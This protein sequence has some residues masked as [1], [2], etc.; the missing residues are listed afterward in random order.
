MALPLLARLRGLI[1]A[2]GAGRAVADMPAPPVPASQAQESDAM[3]S[4]RALLSAGELARA[5]A[6]LEPFS[7]S[8]H[9]LET[10]LLLGR[11][12]LAQGE[13]GAA[14]DLLRHALVLHPSSRDLWETAAEIHEMRREW[15]EALACWKKVVFATPSPSAADCVSWV[16]AHIR[17]AKNRSAHPGEVVSRVWALLD[18]APDATDEHRLGFAEWLYVLQPTT[19]TATDI[20]DRIRPPRAGEVDVLATWVGMADWCRKAGRPLGRCAAE[21]GGDVRDVLLGDLT[22]VLISPA[23]QWIPVL[24]GGATVLDQFVIHRMKTRRELTDSPVLLFNKRTARLR[25]KREPRVVET[26]ALL[27]GGMPQFYHHT[28]E[29]LSG[30]AVADRCGVGQDLPVVV[31]EDLAPFQLEQLALLGYGEDRLIRVGADEQV[32][33]RELLVPSRLVRGGQWMHPM[34]ADWH[35]SR[36]AVPPDHGLPRPRLYLSRRRASRR[37]VANEEALVALLES[38][39]FSTVYPED[40]GIAQQIAL[41]KGATH[42]FSA[43]GAALANMVYMPAGGVV[44]AAATAYILQSPADIYFDKLADACGHRFSWL[45][46]R[47]VEFVG[48]RLVDADIEVDL[49]AVQRVLAERP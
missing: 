4:A 8:S 20:Y 19:T 22:D 42:V 43:A 12:R 6:L 2:R 31:N 27:L 46:C 1:P 9:R 17:V 48:E 29:F 25:L 15:V 26:R 14:D 37:R 10:L 33:F 36:F 40:M 7:A 44:V 30:M 16:R 38:H 32:L 11:L 23:F 49:A 28:I 39:G 5:R 47:P 34:I 35:R 21:E 13:L 3:A 41:F 24:D 45:E 18:R